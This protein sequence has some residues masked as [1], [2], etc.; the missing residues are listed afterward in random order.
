MT[1]QSPDCRQVTSVTTW[2]SGSLQYVLPNSRGHER[3][4]FACVRPCNTV[5]SAC[6]QTQ[7]RNPHKHGVHMDTAHQVPQWELF[8]AL[9]R[10]GTLDCTGFQG[11]V[12]GGGYYCCCGAPSHRWTGPGAYADR[13]LYVSLHFPVQSPARVHRGPER[14]IND[15]NSI[16]RSQS[17]FLDE[18]CRHFCVMDDE[19][20]GIMCVC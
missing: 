3:A 7:V 5:P 8:L 9:Y 10:S 11:S 1:K 16:C 18:Q 13:T 4:G 15:P 6:T 19:H 17:Y 12:R 2:Q 20:A 14:N